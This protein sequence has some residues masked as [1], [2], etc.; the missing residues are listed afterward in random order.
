MTHTFLVLVTVGLGRGV[1]KKLYI[2]I[3][4]R[5][6]EKFENHWIRW[7]IVLHY[8]QHFFPRKAKTFSRGLVPPIVT[9]LFSTLEPKKEVYSFAISCENKFLIYWAGAENKYEYSYLEE[10]FLKKHL[11]SVECRFI[12]PNMKDSHADPYLPLLTPSST[13][14]GLALKRLLL[15]FTG[16]IHWWF[17]FF[18]S[19]K[20]YLVVVL[21]NFQDWSLK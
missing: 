6:A 5:R 18:R 15:T 14:R 1:C 17:I 11:S 9:V 3:G 20:T 19:M 4:G 13:K 16:Y 12:E 8:V 7:T 2:L 21:F 10:R